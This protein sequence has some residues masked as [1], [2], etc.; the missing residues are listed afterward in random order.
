MPILWR[1]SAWKRAV[2]FA[3][4]GAIAALG[5]APQDAWPLSILALTAAFGLSASA[6][7]HRQNMALWFFVGVGYFAVSLR[8]IIEPFLVDIARHGWMAPFAIVF[9]AAGFALFWGAAGWVGAKWKSSLVLVATLTLAEATRSLILTGFPWALVGHIWIDTPIAQIA[10]FTGPHGL[11]LLTFGLAASLALVLQRRWLW[12]SV[13]IAVAIAWPLLAPPALEIPGE[14]R[15]IVRI[16]HPNIPQME[17]WDPALRA[18]NFDRLLQ[19]TQSETPV[20][21]VVWPE[22]AVTELL[23]N[24]YPSFNVMSDVAG[25]A[26]V[27][28]GVQRRTRPQIYQNA[29]AVLGR[30]GEIE[31]I[32]DKQHLVP[33]GEYIPGGEIAARFG[34]RGLA[35]SEGGGFTAGTGDK[36]LNLPGLGS[37]RPLICYEAIFPEEVRTP[38]ERPN[39]LVVITNDAWFGTGLGPTQHLKQAQLLSIEFGLPMIRSANSGISAVIDGYGRIT[40]QMGLNEVGALQSAVPKPLNETIY[41]RFGDTPVLLMTA[42][43]GLFGIARCLRKNN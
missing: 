18:R 24:A 16:V 2:T 7:S 28:T 40:A 20:D 8:W 43:I 42:L 5:Q 3:L 29:F 36:L 34:I 12:G 38:G 1:Q 31:G 30:G 35:P 21:L 14:D 9:M 6:E 37:I 4:L 10:A 17:K 41:A 19:L 39:L 13:P 32:Y 27:I 26:T 25:G 33:F 15:P 23:E 22:S 11:N